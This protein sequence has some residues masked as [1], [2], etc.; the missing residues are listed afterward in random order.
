MLELLSSKGQDIIRVG[1]DLEK[2]KPL[3]TIGGNVNLCSQM[4]NSME[5]P[6]KLK[7]EI[8]YDPAYSLLGI[9]PKK[10]KSSSQKDICIPIFVVTLF[11]IAK[12]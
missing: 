1:E 8:S 11:T 12:T 7:I 5:M 3:C 2:R 9:Y 10:M 4:K 6:Q